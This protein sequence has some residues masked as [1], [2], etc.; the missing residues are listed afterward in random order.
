MLSIIPVG[1]ALIGLYW[2]RWIGWKRKELPLVIPILF[3]CFFLPKINLI[4]VSTLST[5]GIRIDDFLTL[6]LLLI[7]VM[8]PASYRHKV[9]KWSLRMMLLLSVVN[10]LSVFVG[11]IKGYDNSILHAILMVARKF[12]YFAFVPVGIYTVR[13][14]KNPYKT[15][16]TEF[17]WMSVLHMLPAILQV[18]GKVTYAVNGI[19]R[20]DY[21][22]GTAAS[23]FNGYYEYGQFLCFGCAVYISDLLRCGDTARILRTKIPVSA[24]LLPLTLGMLVLSNSRTS[25][26]TGVIII[27]VALVFPIQRTVS[28]PRLILLGYGLLGVLAAGTL[29][30]SGLLG[31]G[32]L[33]RVGELNMDDLFGK[34]ARELLA[35]GNFRQYVTLTRTA[36]FEYNAIDT[37]DYLS[38]VSDW[39]A[40]VRLLKWGAALDGF[41]LNPLL[42]Y[43][44]GVLHVIDGHYVRLLGE[45]GILGTALWLVFYFGLM[46]FVWRARRESRFAVAVVLVMVS[47]LLNAVTIDMFDASRPMGMMYLLVGGV[48]AAAD[49]QRKRGTKS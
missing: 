10:L 1:A 37:L 39:S 33:R 3:T 17:T 29:V 15:F 13:K 34:P 40:A 25:L 4:K 24:V 18:L 8:D 46:R 42:G 21:L 22:H 43:G 32:V 9:V 47:I 12:E 20:G 28:R 23:T 49:F 38:K 11:R 31:T 26:L 35:R 16:Y 5:A 30:Y 2:L 45:T 27:A 44:F 36:G 41:R 6:L 19:D 7:A 14:L 48:L